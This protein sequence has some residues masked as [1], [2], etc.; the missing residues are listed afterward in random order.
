MFRYHFPNKRKIK[1]FESCLT[2]GHLCGAKGNESAAVE[3]A[4]EISSLSVGYINTSSTKAHGTES[5]TA[6]KTDLGR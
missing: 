2:F 1:L 4:V 6:A 5:I 3:F